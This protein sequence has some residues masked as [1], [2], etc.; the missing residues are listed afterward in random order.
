MVLVERFLG[1]Q[2][3]QL[4]RVG[5]ILFGHLAQHVDNKWTMTIYRTRD[6]LNVVHSKVCQTAAI[7]L[8]RFW[9]PSEP[10]WTGT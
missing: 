10:W 5:K 3:D 8:L 7:P 2:G 6:L 1:L 9:L 4:N